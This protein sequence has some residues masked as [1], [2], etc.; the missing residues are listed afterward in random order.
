MQEELRFFLDSLGAL[1]A[2]NTH[3]AV[4]A[5]LTPYQNQLLGHSVTSEW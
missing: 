1:I 5:E 3:Y 4:V 2:P